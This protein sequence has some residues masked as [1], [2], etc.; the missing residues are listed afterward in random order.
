MLIHPHQISTPMLISAALAAVWFGCATNAF[1]SGPTEDVTEAEPKMVVRLAAAET[2]LIIGVAPDNIRIIDGDTLVVSGTRVRL[3]GVDAPEV[4]QTCR[5]EDDEAWPCGEAA[6]NMLDVVTFN[7]TL[8][9]EPKGESHERVVAACVTDQGNDV[10]D[11]MVSNGLALDVP[12]YSKGH[13]EEVQE[14]A[15]GIG[16]GVWQGRF[17][18]PWKY[19]KGE[20]LS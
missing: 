13:Y 11:L 12:E 5:N 6:K 8:T 3:W 20:R 16:L 18:E 19:R 4:S 9:C 1:G 17:V 10:G 7:R 2:E 15:R 14:I